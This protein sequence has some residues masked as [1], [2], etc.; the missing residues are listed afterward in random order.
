MALPWT[1]TDSQAKN[2]Y[3]KMCNWYNSPENLPNKYKDSGV[4]FGYANFTRDKLY[5][6]IQFLKDTFSRGWFTTDNEERQTILKDIAN[7]LYNIFGGAVDVNGI[8][9]FLNWVYNF[10]RNDTT[11]LNYFQGGAY[12]DLQRLIDTAAEKIVEPINEAAETVAYG[13]NYPS[14]KLSNPLVKWG[15]IIGG[16]LLLFKTLKR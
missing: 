1:L 6:C 3:T 11:A 4:F 12:G 14:L 7:E 10:A 13:V 5:Y 2:I 9:K 8:Y 15:L 16:G